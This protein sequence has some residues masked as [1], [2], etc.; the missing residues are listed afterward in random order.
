[1]K[2]KIL[3]ATD[4]S[5]SADKAIDFAVKLA[6]K[7]N[8]QETWLKGHGN[9]VMN[10]SEFETQWRQNYDPVLY[11]LQVANPAER[12]KI[13]AGLAPDEAASLAP[14]HAGLVALGALGGQASGQ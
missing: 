7:T 8:A 12:R 10:H 6:D 2:S 3:C 1:M 9:G 4:G 13:I 11:Q 14:K 5:H